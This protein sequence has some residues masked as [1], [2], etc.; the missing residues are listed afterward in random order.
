MDG[1]RP[2]AYFPNPQ[3]QSSYFNFR[4]RTV[5]DFFNDVRKKGWKPTLAD[6]RMWGQMRMDPTDLADVSG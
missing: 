4:Q 1:S 3:I 5:G 2:R 6:R